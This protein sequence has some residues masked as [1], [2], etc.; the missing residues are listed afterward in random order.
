MGGEG[1]YRDIVMTFGYA[2]LPLSLIGI[3]LS[4]VTNLLTYSEAGYVTIL[5]GVAMGWC[6]F[7]LF[8]GLL[9]VHQYSFGKTLATALLTLVAMAVLIFIAMVFMELV[10]NMTGFVTAL[11]K[12]IMTR[13]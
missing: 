9:T 5:Q 1:S 2:C 13:V 4:F 6:L 11:F 12:E 7:L 10:V 3:P 8:F